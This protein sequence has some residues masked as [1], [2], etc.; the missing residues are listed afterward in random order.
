MRSALP[1]LLLAACGGP[2][3]IYEGPRLPSAEVSQVVIEGGVAGGTERWE[4]RLARLDG[5]P[6]RRTHREIELLP[7]NHTLDV[8]W[9][10]S[11][12][13]AGTRPAWVPAASGT[14]E[15]TFELRGGFRYVLFWIGGDQPLRFRERPIP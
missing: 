14:M 12:R 11:H 1:L 8:A 2:T 5:L 13:M 3:R 6:L 7:G 10:L 15:M 4:A 9:T